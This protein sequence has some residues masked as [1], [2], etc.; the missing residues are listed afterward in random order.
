M[1]I[2]NI[3]FTIEKRFL[4]LEFDEKLSFQ[5]DSNSFALVT[6]APKVSFIIPE[7]FL[8]IQTTEKLRQGEKKRKVRQ[9]A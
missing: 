2:L 9:R 7:N 6:R 3:S 4:Y 5:D 1:N 8:K